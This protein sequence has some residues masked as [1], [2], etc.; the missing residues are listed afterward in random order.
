[1][2]CDLGAGSSMYK[3]LSIGVEWHILVLDLHGLQLSPCTSW[4]VEFLYLQNVSTEFKVLMPITSLT[5]C[6]SPGDKMLYGSPESCNGQIIFYRLLFME[7]ELLVQN[8]QIYV[9]K[10]PHFHP[11][12]EMET[13]PRSFTWLKSSILLL[14]ERQNKGQ[15]K[16]W[17]SL[18]IQLLFI[19]LDSQ[20]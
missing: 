19:S 17:I 20:R 6:R 12:A 18:C 9:C 10:A 4:G 1:M 15:C 14:L 13:C 8:S 2:V 11:L 16:L 5:D 3:S 7:E